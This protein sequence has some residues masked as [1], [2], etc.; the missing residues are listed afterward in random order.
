MED[1]I[2]PV[3]WLYFKSKDSRVEILPVS[4]GIFP[5]IE[6]YDNSNITSFERFNRFGIAPV[7]LLFLRRISPRVLPW[8]QAQR[9][10]ACEL[11][12]PKFMSLSTQRANSSGTCPMNL[13]RL[14]S[15]ELRN[16]KFPR[17]GSMV[18]PRLKPDGSTLRFSLWHHKKLQSSYKRK[19]GRWWTSC[20]PI[21]SKDQK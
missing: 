17:R 4:F 10:I 12:N 15:R 16:V 9:H 8:N 13:L 14:R 20:W 1:G 3:S 21:C 5:W 2:D 18:P 11:L 6:L 7:K 19:T